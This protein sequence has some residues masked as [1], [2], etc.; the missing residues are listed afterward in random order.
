MQYCEDNK[1]LLRYF[2]LLEI[3]RFIKYVND[4]NHIEN[5]YSINLYFKTISDITMNSLKIYYL[6]CLKHINISQWNHIYNH[7]KSTKL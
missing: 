2:D 3:I 5:E 7:I 1:T 6:E 4:F